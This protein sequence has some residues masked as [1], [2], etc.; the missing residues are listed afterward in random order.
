MGIRDYTIYSIIK[1]NAKVDSSRIALISGEKKIT[2]GQFLEKVDRLAC[3][4]LKIGLKK[5]DRIGVLASNSLEYVYLYGAAAKIGAIMLPINWRLNPQEIEYILSDGS[6]RVVFVGSDFQAI[7]T[8]LISKFGFIERCF[9]MDEPLG[10]F[11]S[12]DGLMENDGI[13]PDVDISCDD[14]YFIIYTAA[15]HGRPR[16]A[17]LSHQNIITSNLHI[18]YCWQVTKEDAHILTLPLFHLFGLCLT[19]SVMQAGGTNIIIPRFE[20]DLTLKCIQE[21]RATILGEF[22][23]MLDSLLDKA[24]ESN[25]NLSS[26]RIVLGL[27]RPETI[28]R[29]EANTKATFWAAYAQAETTSF[30][31]LAPYSEKPGSSGTL[32]FIADVEITDRHGRIMETGKS[33]E[34]VVR[35]PTVFNGYWNLK[36]DN[37]YTFRD[38]WHHTGDMGHFDKD[39]Y[40][41][42]DGRS[43]EKE[44][45]KSGGENVYP[46]EVEKAILE[47]P[48]VKEV[49]VI[50]VPDPQW[51]EVVKAVCVLRKGELLNESELTGFVGARIAKF[52]RPKYVVFV[53]DL[54]KNDDGSIDKQKVKSIYSKN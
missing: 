46:V 18:M 32:G 44:L 10:D 1:R 5:Y 23:P 19:F 8:P 43:Q 31:T 53:S 45:I 37:E 38:N 42:Y 33:G 39:G 17:T 36:E 6:P 27:D 24:Q 50:G 7:V 49:A 12:F 21:D 35:G 20:V 22:P 16:G 15:I 11:A 47:H 54:P 52:K 2:Y 13:C 4:L 48:L 30:I 9:T 14:N 41:W 51:G 25:Y 34:I 28:K 3:G 40:L 29:L 26:L